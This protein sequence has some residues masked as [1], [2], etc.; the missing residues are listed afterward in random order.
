MAKRT[1]KRSAVTG[2]FITKAE[3]R[4]NPE[5]TVRETRVE[6]RAMFNELATRLDAKAAKEMPG[7]ALWSAYR[8]AAMM[9]REYQAR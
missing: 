9:A 5:T 4:A 7:S 3:E 8:N 1:I 6:W 2:Q